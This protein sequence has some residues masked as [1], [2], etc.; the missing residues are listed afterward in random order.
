MKRAISR[1]I[2][3]L[4]VLCVAATQVPAQGLQPLSDTEKAARWATENEL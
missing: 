2:F 3:S 1:L 4:V